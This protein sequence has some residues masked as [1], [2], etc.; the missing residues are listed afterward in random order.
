MEKKFNMP[1]EDK[2]KYHYRMVYKLLRDDI[3]REASGGE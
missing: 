2:L 3:E 1:D